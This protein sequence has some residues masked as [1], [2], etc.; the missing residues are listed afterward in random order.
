MALRRLG[1]ILVDLGYISD[2]QLEVLVEEQHER[3][4][5]LIG[6]VAMDM[7]LITDDQLAQALGNSLVA[8]HQVVAGPVARELPVV[9]DVSG[10]FAVGLLAVVQPPSDDLVTIEKHLARPDGPVRRVR[11]PRTLQR[12]VL[13]NFRDESREDCHSC[14]FGEDPTPENHRFHQARMVLSHTVSQARPRECKTRIQSRLGFLHIGGDQQDESQMGA[15]A[16]TEGHWKRQVS[17]HRIQLP[18][19]EDTH[20]ISNLGRIL[21]RGIQVE[22]AGNA[23]ACEPAGILDDW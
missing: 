13:A 22:L 12:D 4:G 23:S 20:A 11:R 3:P 16:R 17:R 5:Q 18:L 10:Q 7:G 15:S 14:V 6:Q 2:E 8:G 21:V 19:Q 1:Q 9:G